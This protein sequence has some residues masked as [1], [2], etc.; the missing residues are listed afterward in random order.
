ME[1]STKPCLPT[2]PPGFNAPPSRTAP[3]SSWCWCSG[4]PATAFGIPPV[5]SALTGRRKAEG[6]VGEDSRA[7]SVWESPREEI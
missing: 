2:H 3:V 6:V 4:D 5:S 7:S 1:K